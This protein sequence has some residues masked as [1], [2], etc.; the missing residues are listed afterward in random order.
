MYNIPHNI[1]II[2]IIY[3]IFTSLC[4]SSKLSSKHLLHIKWRDKVDMDAVDLS[5]V[6]LLA[7]QWECKVYVSENICLCV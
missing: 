1:I 2:I 4:T 6:F 3:I 5:T 7:C